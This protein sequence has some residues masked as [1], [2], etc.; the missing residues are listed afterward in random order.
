MLYFEYIS[1]LRYLK[2]KTTFLRSSKKIQ[3]FPT[4]LALFFLK[5]LYILKNIV[6]NPISPR[7]INILPSNNEDKW[8]KPFS[9]N[10]KLCPSWGTVGGSFPI[11]KMMLQILVFQTSTFLYW[12]FRK[13]REGQSYPKNFI[14]DFSVP[15]KHFLYWIFG[16]RGENHS[17]PEKGLS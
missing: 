7:N 5:S 16:K 9:G 6:P 1:Y 4:F 2:P 17:Y 12:I 11:Q 15:N 3:H 8:K 14:A 13:R 10:T